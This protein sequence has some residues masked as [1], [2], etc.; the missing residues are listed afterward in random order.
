MDEGRELAEPAVGAS[1]QVRVSVFSTAPPPF[2]LMG[3]A[4]W[5]RKHR[6][7][8]LRLL[9]VRRADQTKMGCTA[10]D[11]HDVFD[12][13]YWWQTETGGILITPLPGAPPTKPG[14]ATRP[15]PGIDADVV[16]RE[17]QPVGANKGGF[18]VLKKPWPGML[19]TIYGDPD[20]YVQ[21]YWSQI[22]GMYFTGDARA[23]TR[24][25]T[26]DRWPIATW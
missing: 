15:F 4:Q 17:G 19:R 16:T 12:R 7:D 22:D 1:S 20:R 2:A 9:D 3:G 5:P 21:Q 6:L 18:L 13:R 26:S 8:R 10:R 14:S 23:G 11:G 24:T 25:A